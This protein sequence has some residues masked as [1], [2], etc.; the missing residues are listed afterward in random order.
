L[1]RVRVKSRPAESEPCFLVPVTDNKYLADFYKD[2][3]KYAFP[4][5]VYLLNERF[6][7]QQSSVVFAF[8]A[9]AQLFLLQ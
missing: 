8:S 1:S 5:Q 9:I 3:G 6:K 7:Q 2:I 4:M